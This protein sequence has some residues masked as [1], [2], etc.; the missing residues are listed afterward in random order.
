MEQVMA[1]NPKT[2]FQIYW[3]GTRDQ[4][5]ARLDR[6]KRA[7]I[8]GLIVTLDWSFSHGR[9]WGSPSIPE[10]LDL[11]TSL[12]HSPNLLTPPPNAWRSAPYPL[13]HPAL[14][15]LPFPNLFPTAE[16]AP[17]SLGGRERPPSNSQPQFPTRIPAF[18]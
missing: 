11:K 5:T 3:C 6:A 9:D 7:G 12:K 17:G 14:P 4:M 13:Q 1:E 15:D 10:Q 16:Q 8:P 18:S 2:F